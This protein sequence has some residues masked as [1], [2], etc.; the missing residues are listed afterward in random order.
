MIVF[1][2]HAAVDSCNTTYKREPDIMD[3]S[4]SQVAVKHFTK[5][6]ERKMLSK[7]VFIK[8]FKWVFFHRYKKF[9]L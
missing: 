3:R 5:R 1:I 2:A 4:T 8:P 6:E 7:I 9:G